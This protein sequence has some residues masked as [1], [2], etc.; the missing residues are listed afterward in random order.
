MATLTDKSRRHIAAKNFALS[1]VRKYPIE[2]KSH[3]INAKARATQ[4]YDKGHISKATEERVDRAAN[5]KL[6]GVKEHEQDHWGD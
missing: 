5:R 1:A 3:A 2:N 4:E 6:H